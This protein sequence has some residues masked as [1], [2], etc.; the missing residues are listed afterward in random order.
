MDLFFHFTLSSRR[1]TIMDGVNSNSGSNWNSTSTI[2]NENQSEPLQHRKRRRRITRFTSIFILPLFS[3][4]LLF[5]S[6][7][8]NLTLS[9]Q[10]SII[11]KC[12][13]S[14]MRPAY[15]D[16]SSQLHQFTQDRS[17]HLDSLQLQLT[18][19]YSLYLYRERFL[20]SKDEPDLKNGRPALF[21]PGNAGSYGQVRSVA[22]SSA[23]WFWKHDQDGLAVGTEQ[24][25]EEWKDNGREVDW[26]TS[27]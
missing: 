6:L 23:K 21:V 20:H 27:E 10:L 17:N 5:Y 24:K 13:M 22:S 15:L 16:Y 19:K 11:Q 25:N 3:F 2:S 9:N 1:M 12:K 8:S 7:N 18:K 14:R 4:L 26:W